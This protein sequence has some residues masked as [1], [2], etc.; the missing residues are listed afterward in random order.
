MAIKPKV[1]FK[2]KKFLIIDDFSEFRFTVKKMVQSFG[3][4][5][6]DDAGDGEEAV[7]KIS[8][9]SFDIILCDY[10]LGEGRKTGQQILEEIKHRELIK[11]STIF[12]MITAENTMDM[13]MGALEY[14]P[15]D[16]LT[17]PFNK[18]ILQNRL[19]KQV[20]RKKDMGKIEKAVLRKE[21]DRA[22]K[23][24]DEKI[25]AGS[26]NIF[27]FYRLKGDIYLKNGDYEKA[28]TV[29]EEVLAKYELPWAK[30]ALGK[31]FFYEKDYLEARDTFEEVIEDNK[32]F[33]EAYDWLSKTLVKLGDMEEAQQVL[34][35]AIEMSPKAILRQ[36]ALGEVAFKNKDFNTAEK[37]LKTTVDLGK[38]SVFKAASDY[39][40]LA[41]VLVEKEDPE[42]A[43]NILQDSRTEFTND[44]KAT[45]ETAVI[46]GLAYKELNMESEAKKSIEEAE[47]LS[48]GIPGKLPVDVAMDMARVCLSVGKNEEGR[49]LIQQ[50]VK[51]HHDDEEILK[52][53]QDVYDDA[54]LKD[55][56]SQVIKSARKEIIDINNKG[57]FLV[58]EGKLDEACEFFEK[59]AAGLPDNKIINANAA[60]SLI[61]FMQKFGKEDRL[62]YQTRKYLD[63]VVKIDPAYKKYRQLL[64]AF[65]QL[66]S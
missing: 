13:V 1:N 35:N 5:E 62:M 10:N 58:K 16:Y 42:E 24:L 26:K 27:D 33:M 45:M 40:T 46:E 60:Q 48:K 65:Q 32:T 30:L 4:T 43:L 57:V 25:G 20:E 37:S 29:F 3:A 31:V 59:A 66:D 6:I 15:D 11:F 44:P 17:K 38:T 19:E 53:A 36:K 9:N 39:T 2:D 54:E 34:M 18:D 63:R 64:H 47:K 21:Y 61:M 50:V 51:N 12:I 56:G 22:I 28:K 41:K 52:Q 7:K 14:R 8:V 49:K 55:E 23:L